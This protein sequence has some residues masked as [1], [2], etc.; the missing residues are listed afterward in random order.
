MKPLTTADLA[1][2]LRVAPSSVRK[3]KLRGL[4]PSV[5]V[6]GRMYFRPSQLIAAFETFYMGPPR[7]KPS[8]FPGDWMKP[9]D[10]A[11]YLGRSVETV[12]RWLHRGDLP[13][14]RLGPHTIRFRRSELVDQLG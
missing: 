13:Y 7:E 4:I 11:E 8:C 9:V 1:A 10:V 6:G 3:M 5:T 12:Y 2:M 14:Y